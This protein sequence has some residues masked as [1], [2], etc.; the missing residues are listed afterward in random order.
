MVRLAGQTEDTLKEIPGVYP[1]ATHV[2]AALTASRAA[3]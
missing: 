3:P 2:Q 1:G